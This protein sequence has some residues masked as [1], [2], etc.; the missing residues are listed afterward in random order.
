MGDQNKFIILYMFQL[1]QQALNIHYVNSD[2][3]W[4]NGAGEEQN[5]SYFT[6]QN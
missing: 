5:Y 4:Y 6:E 1:Q 3:R 2:I